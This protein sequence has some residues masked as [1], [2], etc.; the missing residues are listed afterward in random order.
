[1]KVL[2]ISGKAEAGKDTVAQALKKKLEPMGYKVLVV[3]YADLLKYICKTFFEWDGKKDEHGRTLLQKIGTEVIREQ[4]PEYW[5][6]FI[7][8]I[9]HF[10]PNEWNFVI[11][12]DCRFPNEIKEIEEDFDC[13]SVRVIRPDYQN[14]LTDEQRLHS[15]ETALDDWRFD[16]YLNNPGDEKGLDIELDGFIDELFKR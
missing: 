13:S 2:A 4:Q 14:H 6:S 12:P 15:S 10:F 8:D 7:K 5:I 1:M 11:I 16:Y 3:H 9:L